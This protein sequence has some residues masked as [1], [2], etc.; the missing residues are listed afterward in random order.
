MTLACCHRADHPTLDPASTPPHRPE[1][2][3][4]V[5]RLASENSTWGYR[6]PRSHSP[7]YT[8]NRSVDPGSVGEA[9]GFDAAKRRL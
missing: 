2:R 7:Q 3:R 9:Q 8:R 6:R 5:L 4:L 1:L